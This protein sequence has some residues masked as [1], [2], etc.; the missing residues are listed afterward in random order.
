MKI[1]KQ[2]IPGSDQ[3]PILIKYYIPEKTVFS[4]P[5]LIVHGFKGFMDWGHF[6]YVAQKIAAKGHLVVMM[7]ISHNGTSPESPTDF[8]RLDLFA[9][10]TY[11]RELFDIGKV[12]DELETSEIV[13]DNN[14]NG[15]EVILVGHS[16]GGAMSIITA[17]EDKRVKKLVTWAAADSA[18]SFWAKDKDLVREWKEKGV[19]YIPNARTNQEM[20]VNYSL[21]EDSIAN[22]ARLDV[23]QAAGTVR[24]P[25]LIIHGSDDP[26]IPVEAAHGFKVKQPQAEVF[27][28]EH[29]HHNFGGKHPLDETAD[30][31]QI[32][33]LAEKTIEFAEGLSEA[34]SE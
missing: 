8:V 11:S 2:V 18:G 30:F 1:E 23:K 16:R 3:K 28:M 10:N 22:A 29:A 9:K 17:S 32:N 14:A 27:I 13:R 4:S 19:F 15:A 24:V 34:D 31:N 12:L 7:N 26:T 25:W 20:P 5:I 6:P 21:Y 33:L